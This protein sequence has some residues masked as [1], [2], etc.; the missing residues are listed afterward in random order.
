GW[1]RHFYIA[2]TVPAESYY[3][4]LQP[5]MRSTGMAFEFTPVYNE[6]NSDRDILAINLDKAYRN[7]TEK[8]RWGGLENVKAPGDI[9]LD[10]TVRRMVTTH[11][12]YITET[13]TAFVN[14]AILAAQAA[15]KNPELADSEELKAFQA[16]RYAKA[17]ELMKLC[18]E[19]LP[20]A[21]A[22]Y[23]L[24]MRQKMAQVYARIGIATGNDEYLH[25]ALDLLETEIRRAGHNARYYQSLSPWQYTTLSMNDRYAETYYLVY[26]LQDYS[27]LGGDAEAMIHELED[28][29]VNFDRIANIIEAQTKLKQQKQQQQQ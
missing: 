10:E 23:A 2:S 24:Q 9:Y 17:L 7:I 18:E 19:K 21:A 11:R 25:H 20:E 13:A 1:K 26:L 22:P 16:D 29:G 15:E 27:D 28:L 4:G 6:E 14:E 5:Y 12:T 3:L 8:F